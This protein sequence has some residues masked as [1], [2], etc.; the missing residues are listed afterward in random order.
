MS[1]V[2][3]DNIISPLG[4][5]SEANW[6]AVKEGRTALLPRKGED[7]HVKEDFTAAIIEDGIGG[8]EDRILRS[9]RKAIEGLDLLPGRTVLV[10]STTKGSLGSDKTIGESAAAIAEE[11]GLD[12]EPIVVSNA[13]VSGLAAIILADRLLRLG[14]YDCAIVSGTDEVGRFVL[15]GFQSL[16]ATSPFPCRPFDMERRGLNLGEAV[17]TVVLCTKQPFH[18]PPTSLPPPPSGAGEAAPPVQCGRSRDRGASMSL[19][20][21]WEET[22]MRRLWKI[23]G[24]VIRND[25]YNITTPS[26]TAEGLGRCLEELLGPFRPDALNLHGTATLF[27]DQMESVAVARAGLSDVP[28]SALKGYF[29]HTLGAAGIVETI[30]S[31]KAADEGIVPGTKGFFE[32]GVSG[33]VNLSSECRGVKTDS[34]IKMLSGFGGCNA[35]VLFT[36]AGEQ[37]DIL[38]S[39]Y[40]SFITTHSITLRPGFASV[41]GKEIDPEGDLAGMYKR[42]IGNYP[43]FHKMDG[44]SKLGFVA[45]ELLLQAERE[46]SLLHGTESQ[47]PG[48]HGTPFTAEMPKGDESRAVVLFNRSSSIAADREYI[49]S[50][51]EGFPSPSTFIYTLPNI[52]TG[53]IAI[54][55]GWH[56]ETSLYILRDHSPRLEEEILSASFLDKATQSILGGRIDYTDENHYLAEL[57][58]LHLE[59]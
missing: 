15:S 12:T 9:V 17:G 21:R 6:L 49:K 5:T 38:P 41:D 8:F 59:S 58:I 3:A 16:K 10:L 18:V 22:Q 51:D 2:I 43:K 23:E 48:E 20:S 13:C 30:I 47:D 44:L 53:E 50:M 24:G 40:H 14:S 4:E 57:Q 1:V 42:Y 33:R 39:I 52:V 7:C 25:A 31:M 19:N 27:N 54:R 46:D 37:Y 56:G 35:A 32:A 45:S 55:N 34:L 26:R 29:G 36:R 11:L 28:A